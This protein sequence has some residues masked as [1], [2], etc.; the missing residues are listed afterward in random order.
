MTKTLVLVEAPSKA[1]HIQQFLGADYI[2]KASVGHITEMPVPKNMT[3]EEKAKYKEYAMT[4]EDGKFEPLFRVASD[5]KKIVAELKRILKTVDEV[6]LATDS[7]DEGAAISWHLL[8]QLKPKVPT[9]RATW[10]EITDKAV[11]EGLKNKKLVNA[12]TKEPKDFFGQAESAITRA[13]LDRL[14]GYA[15]SPY[16]WKTV[17]PGTSSGRV[18]TPGTRLIVEREERRLAFKSVA[19]YSIW[20]EFDGTK[21]KLVEFD[22]KK[23]ADG[24]KLDDDGNLTKGYTLI[25]DDNLDSVMKSLKAKSYTVSDVTSKPYRRSPP[26]PFTTSTALQSIGGKT[27]QSAKQITRYL[28]E[29]YASDAAITYIRTVSVVASPEA[30]IEARKDIA[31]K[32]GPALVPSSQRVYK[33]KGSGNSGHE[34]IRAV[35]DDKTGK[36]VNRSFSDPKKQEIFDL[37]NLRFLASQAIDC[38]GTT[39]TAAFTA[40]DGKAKFTTSETEIHEP[41]WTKIYQVD[42][43]VGA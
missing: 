14:Y 33:D 4:M 29:L 1:K 8:D 30:I 16:V 18:Q 13:S 38:E 23:I 10:N 27:R 7:D 9:Y 2:V 26:A 17:K 41:G 39:W 21:A 40:K 3:A 12:N 5:K 43:E 11:K 34:C 35:L 36:L 15:S 22:E 19:F 6:V 31:K 24:S 20:G 37:V 25:T 28:Q 32:F 42:E